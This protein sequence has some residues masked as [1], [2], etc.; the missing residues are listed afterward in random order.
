LIYFFDSSKP[1]T[2]TPLGE[3]STDPSK[4]K[5]MVKGSIYEEGDE[6]TVYG[7]CFRGDGS[8]LPA[9]N[10]TFSSWFSNGTQWQFDEAMTSL[11]NS[12]RWYIHT[13][14]TSTTGTYLTQIKC[15]FGGNTAIAFGEWQNPAW[16]VRIKTI[17]DYVVAINGTVVSIES[18]V[19]DLSVQINNNISTVLTQ[20][21]NLSTFN[22]S[23][24]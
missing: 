7:A 22:Y 9:A 12:G 11:N 3:Q 17:N 24:L 15:T 23:V 21:G 19:D 10:A 1:I 8:L 6:M 18:K 5:A 20:I 16:V 4:L 13:N 2:Y 14:M